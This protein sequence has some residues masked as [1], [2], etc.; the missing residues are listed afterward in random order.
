MSR[1]TDFPT[2]EQQSNKG[3]VGG[4]K[5]E[6]VGRGREEGKIVEA[7]RSRVQLRGRF[8]DRWTCSARHHLRN[9]PLGI[10]PIRGTSVQR[11]LQVIDKTRAGVWGGARRNVIV[12]LRSTEAGER[13]LICRTL[14]RQKIERLRQNKK[15]YLAPRNANCGGGGRGE[16]GVN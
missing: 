9:I 8:S 3:L 7:D 16:G 5:E 11:L 12:K 4:K 13:R 14:R 1:T 2:E 6:K 15:G 10:R